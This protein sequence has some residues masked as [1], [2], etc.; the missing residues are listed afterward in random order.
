MMLRLVRLW[1]PDYMG[2]VSYCLQGRLAEDRPWN[3]LPV[4][5]FH[6]LSAEEQAEIS[7]ATRKSGG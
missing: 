5:D 4:V 3:T 1:A 6:R 2:G 7:E